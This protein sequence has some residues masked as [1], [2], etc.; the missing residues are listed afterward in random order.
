[1][2]DQ[3]VQ[4]IGF[5]GRRLWIALLERKQAIER[6]IAMLEQV[7]RT[8]SIDPLPC[9]D[10]LDMMRADAQNAVE[11]IECTLSINHVGADHRVMDVC[12]MYGRSDR[13]LEVKSIEVGQRHRQNARVEH[14]E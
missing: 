14:I 2:R 11:M 12:V 7:F 6:R 8:Q 1:R 3:Y 4:R 13:T 9:A 5:R 10:F